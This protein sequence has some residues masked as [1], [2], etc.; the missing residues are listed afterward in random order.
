MMASYWMMV[1]CPTK[2]KKIN[3]DKLLDALKGA[4]HHTLCSQYG[5][6][7]GLIAPALKNLDLFIPSDFEIVPYFVLKY[8][9]GE[10]QPLIFESRIVEARTGKNF[11]KDGG[12]NEV[13]V[14]VLD[15]LKRTRTVFLVSL[16]PAQL[17]DMGILLAY[18][19]ARWILEHEGGVLRGLDGRW[20]RLNRHS[21]FLEIG[22]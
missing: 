13:F 18:E 21:A 8:R 1:Y 7:H 6:D 16:T 14:S 17:I 20:Y 2:I 10:A 15:E 12:Q 4:N 19:T 5:L 3:G 11:F 22:R 9:S